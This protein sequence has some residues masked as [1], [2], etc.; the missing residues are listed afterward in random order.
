M[1]Q[2]KKA[3][4]PQHPDSFKSRKTLKVGNKTYVYYSL[5]AAEKNGLKG[6]SQLPNSMKVLLENLLR[7]EDGRT[8]TADDIKAVQSWLTRRKSTREIAYRPARVLM[9][10]FTGVPAV[11]DLA[12]MRNAMQEIGGNANKINPLTPVDLVID[13]SVMVDHAGTSQSL[14]DNVSLEYQR[15]GERYEFLRW[16]AQAFQNFRVVPPRHWYLPPS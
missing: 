2:R 11:V 15:N 1:P 4:T 13:H 7:H 14:K 6:I 16:G 5:K 3:E 12:T 8:V 10:D 9:Q